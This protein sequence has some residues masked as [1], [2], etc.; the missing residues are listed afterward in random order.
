MTVPADYVGN[1]N[2]GYALLALVSENT[3]NQII[4]LL[5]NLTA[6]LPGILW[7]MPRDQLHITL[8]EIIQSKTYTQDKEALY[9]LHSDEYEEVPARILSTMPRFTVALDIIEASPQAVIVR[10]ND[11]SRFNAI[12]ARLLANMQLPSETRTPPDIIHSSIARYLKETELERVQEVV[13]RHKII[14]EE[15]ISEFKL[16]RSEIPPLQKYEVLKTYPL[17]TS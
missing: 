3:K 16:I 11:A 7:P 1:E 12:R 8:C 9:K 10:S 6:K 2:L 4:D 14:I 15:E 17:A 5:D 13:A